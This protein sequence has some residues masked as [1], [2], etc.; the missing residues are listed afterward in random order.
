MAGRAQNA[1]KIAV[2]QVK[3]AAAAARR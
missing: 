2:N 1:A 3:I